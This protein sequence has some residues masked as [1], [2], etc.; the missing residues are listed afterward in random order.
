MV[1]RVPLT[2]MRLVGLILTVGRDP[3]AFENVQGAIDEL[4]TRLNALLGPL[5][6]GGESG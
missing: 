2:D 6:A 5:L 3:N 4:V 1:L